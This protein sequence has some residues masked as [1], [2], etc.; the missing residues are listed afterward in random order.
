MKNAQTEVILELTSKLKN[1]FG[2]QANQ[3]LQINTKIDKT[4]VTEIDLYVS[5]LI[6]KKILNHSKYSHYNFFSEEEFSELTFPAAILDPIDGTRE[7][8]L[9]R[10]ECAVSLAMMNSSSLS[11]EKNYGWIYNPFSG[12]SI[13]SSMPFVEASNKS[14]KKLLGLVSRSEFENGHFN[15][16]LENSDKIDLSP[17]GSVAFKLGLLAAGG[18]DFVISLSPKHIWDIAA[19][20]V[21]CAQ[22]GFHCYQNGKKVSNLNEIA[23][24]GPLVWAPDVLVDEIHS[25]FLK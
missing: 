8:I 20:T 23:I 17:R 7:L 9:K 11:D 5:E 19:G 16:Y 2:P 18:C 22:R 24:K 13:D 4:F 14:S 12:F 6:K 25:Q 21:L 3:S 1:L 10:A 15:R